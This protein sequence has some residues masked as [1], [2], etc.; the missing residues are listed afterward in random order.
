MTVEV[1]LGMH[2]AM[3]AA[4][5][6][7]LTDFAQDAGINLQIYEGR[8]K[9]IY[10]PCAFVDSISET[11]T[12]T[13]LRARVVAADIV[14]IHGLFDSKETAT[15]KDAFVDAFMDWV[16]DNPHVNVNDAI[17]LVTSTVDDPNYVPDWMPPEGQR[18]YYAT[19]IA[20]EGHTQGRGVMV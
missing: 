4:A 1:R 12:Y 6:D 10:P 2:A 19:H 15:Q 5:V 14:V 7:L 8:P 13:G 17:G 3:R 11:V 18:S 20:Y 16:T 9:S